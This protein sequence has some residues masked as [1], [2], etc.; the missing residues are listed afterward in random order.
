[1]KEKVRQSFVKIVLICSLFALIAACGYSFTQT[2]EHIDKRIGKIYVEQF[3][4]KTDQAQ[5]EDY[6]RQAFVNQIIQTSRFKVAAN[7]ETADATIKGAVL[8]LSMS[9]LSYRSN[10]MVA[11]E[12]ATMI[13][14][15]TFRD[16]EGGKII[17]HSRNITGT[18][19]YSIENNINLLPA[20]RKTAF[21]KLANDT[22]ERI[23]G[24]MMSGF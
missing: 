20:T 17:W 10:T 5:L 15:V 8:T 9:P 22:A 1:M 3:T 11:E 7:A 16:S 19:D 23:F 6:V 4:N 13:L 12:R 14:E 21:I 2:G 18:V 24:Q